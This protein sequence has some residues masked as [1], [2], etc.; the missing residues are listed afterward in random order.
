MGAMGSDSGDP[1][2]LDTIT[3][4][5]PQYGNLLVFKWRLL[6]SLPNFIFFGVMVKNFEKKFKIASLQALFRKPTHFFLK[7]QKNVRFEFFLALLG[8][9]FNSKN[10]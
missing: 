2:S 7:N 9:E 5:G 8:R 10:N 4:L 1:G 3:R 6:N